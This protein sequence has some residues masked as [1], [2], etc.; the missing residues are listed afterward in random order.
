MITMDSPDER[1]HK[2]ILV[3]IWS[4]SGMAVW[5]LVEASKVGRW[6]Q[7]AAS[8]SAKLERAYY[9]RTNTAKPRTDL[10]VWNSYMGRPYATYTEFK[11]S[12]NISDTGPVPVR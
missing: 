8:D 9:E 5:D 1:P 2:L 11:A 6:Y 4:R 12:G 10:D 3:S 7:I